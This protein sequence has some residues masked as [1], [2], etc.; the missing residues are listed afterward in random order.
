MKRPVNFFTVMGFCDKLLIFE[1][2][3]HFEFFHADILL[4]VSLVR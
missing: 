3:L 1:F 2:Y 4:Y